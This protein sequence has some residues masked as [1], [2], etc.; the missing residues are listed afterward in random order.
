MYGIGNF[1][2]DSPGR[3]KYK[4]AFPFSLA[5]RLDIEKREAPLPVTSRLYPILSD[6]L[7]TDYL[8]RPVTAEGF[9][10][11]RKEVLSHSH[12]DEQFREL[13]VDDTDAVGAYFRTDLGTENTI[14]PKEY[15]Y[16]WKPL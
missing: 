5:L 12:A 13:L 2:F 11:V 6:D 10:Q 15:L 14:S 9:E 3:N 8:P 1:V 4:K 7:Q 16:D